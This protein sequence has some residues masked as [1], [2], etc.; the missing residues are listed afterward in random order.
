MVELA[1]ISKQFKAMGIVILKERG[2]LSY[3]DKIT[4]FIPE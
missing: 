1:S 2:K 4:K 3:H